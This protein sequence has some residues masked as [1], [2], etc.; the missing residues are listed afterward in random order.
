MVLVDHQVR[1]APGYGWGL[2]TLTYMVNVVEYNQGRRLQF[3]R[4]G[5]YY[6][7]GLPTPAFSAHEL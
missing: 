1:Q 7:K 2:E 5:E 4:F 6:R 3:D